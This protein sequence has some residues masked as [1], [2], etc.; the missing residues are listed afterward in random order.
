ML[1]ECGPVQYAAAAARCLVPGGFFAR[2]LHRHGFAAGINGVVRIATMRGA[3][4]A[5]DVPDF[6][7]RNLENIACV[8]ILK[9]CFDNSPSPS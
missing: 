4:V 9:P 6:L 1:V 2:P 5:V 8:S 7:L 3:A